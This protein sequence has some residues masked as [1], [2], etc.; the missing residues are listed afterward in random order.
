MKKLFSRIGGVVVGFINGLLGAG[1]GM[2][3]VPLLS[4]SGLPTQKAHATSIA[5]IL[6]LSAFSAAL[7]L[8][9]GRVNFWDAAVYLPWGLGGALLGSWLLPRIPSGILRRVFGIFI[10]WAAVRLLLR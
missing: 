4:A 6:P 7:Y 1:G 10:L 2:L 9:D 8:A 5:V 3:A